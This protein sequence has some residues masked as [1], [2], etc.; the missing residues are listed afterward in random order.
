MTVHEIMGIVSS[1][2]LLVP[3]IA[4]LANRLTHYATYPALLVYYVSIFLYNLMSQGQ[5][6]VSEKLIH[7]WG[8]TNNMLD[9][10]L[11][12]IFLSYLY[13]SAEFIRKMRWVTLG[14]I[15]YELAVVAIMGYNVT[16]MTIILGPGIVIVGGFA[17]YFFARYAKQAIESMKSAGK[18][19]IGASLVLAY[20]SYLLIYIMFYIVRTKEVADTFLLY[21]MVSVIASSILTTGIFLEGR[22]VRKIRELQ[23]TRRELREVYKDAKMGPSRRRIPMLDFDRELL[24]SN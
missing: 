1:V 7:F 16:A 15:I 19:F 17:L 18:A 10:P 24:N 8:L 22:R 3:V 5:L 21:Y 20:G 4:I 9:A 23:V 11:M 12:L 2:A 14:Y 13:P 6:P